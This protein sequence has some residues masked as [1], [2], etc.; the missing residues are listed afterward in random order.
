M[1]FIFSVDIKLQNHF[2]HFVLTFMNSTGGDGEVGER[3]MS[4][5]ASY[6]FASVQP[7]EAAPQLD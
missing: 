2:A 6:A 7:Q 3:N 4:S 1:Y 5:Y